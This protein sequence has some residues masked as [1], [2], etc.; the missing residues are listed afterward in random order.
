MGFFS[1]AT[2]LNSSEYR[3]FGPMPIP[4][5][6][7]IRISDLLRSWM[8]LDK[9]SREA[10]TLEFKKAYW[11]IFLAYSERMASLAVR[12]CDRELIVLGLIALGIDGW[13]YDWRENMLLLP[14][15]YDAGL[16]CGFSSKDAFEES[17]GYLSQE[18]AKGL[19]AFLIRSEHD[20][21][22]EAMGYQI[23][24]DTDGF[25]YRRNW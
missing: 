24:S 1:S 20:R 22:I 19:G 5:P 21:S 12:K 9:E 2:W 25:R 18:P 11:T 3:G 16:R 4:I 8:Q 10:A 13:R 6:L 7:D 17:A 15:H 23:G 14:L